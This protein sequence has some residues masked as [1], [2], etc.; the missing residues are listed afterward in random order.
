MTQCKRNEV[1]S[2]TT[3]RMIAK[4]DGFWLDE[5]IENSTSFWLSLTV[6]RFQ[7]RKQKWWLGWNGMRLARSADARH[8]HE[9]HPEIYDWVIEIMEHTQ[10]QTTITVLKTDAAHSVL[11]F[12]C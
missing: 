6:T 4:R 10:P 2:V 9:H 11:S 12:G 7:G 8:L 3:V 1:G 5:Q